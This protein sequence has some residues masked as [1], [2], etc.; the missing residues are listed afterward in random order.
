MREIYS[1]P[2]PEVQGNN[3]ENIFFKLSKNYTD[4]KL[5]LKRITDI[6]YYKDFGQFY[7]ISFTIH[8]RHVH[9]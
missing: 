5:N 3:F 2:E 6:T 4:N 8:L 1:N 7:E 9:L